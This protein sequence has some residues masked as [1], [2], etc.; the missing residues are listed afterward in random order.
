MNAL[1]AAVD[2]DYRI[3]SP[4]EGELG[5][6]AADVNRM[7]AKLGEAEQRLKSLVALS[8]DFFREADSRVAVHAPRRPLQPARSTPLPAPPLGKR[9]WDFGY[10]LE[11]LTSRGAPPASS[12]GAR[13]FATSRSC[14]GASTA[15]SR[16]CLHGERRAGVRRRRRFSRLPGASAATSPSAR[17]SKR[18]VRHA[19]HSLARSE[20][21]FRSVAE[22]SSDWIWATDAELRLTYLSDGYERR[23]RACGRRRARQAPGRR[24]WRLDFAD[25]EP[26]SLSARGLRRARR[27]TT[28]ASHR[29]RPDG[30]RIVVSLSGRPLFS[31][32][33]AFIGYRGI[34]RDV[35]AQAS[36]PRKRAAR[37]ARPPDPDPRDDGRGK[38]G[39]PRRRRALRA[40]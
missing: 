19:Q 33:G 11:R 24:L 31:P 22:M 18:E 34:G 10:R 4:S 8:S 9:F 32:E 1:C 17:R 3:V 37:R 38:L 36:R 39:H 27:S 26:D 16:R 30:T 15:R 35:S 20:A 28:C 6:L 14:A 2:L 12:S 23:E 25:R 13:R 5:Q 29:R 40:R 7:A 21:R